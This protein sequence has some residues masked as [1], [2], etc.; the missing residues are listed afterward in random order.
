MT[1]HSNVV[2]DLHLDHVLKAYQPYTAVGKEVLLTPFLP[3]DEE[4]WQQEMDEQ[5]RIRQRGETQLD[6]MVHLQKHFIEA[7]VIKHLCLKLKNSESLAVTEW[8][9]LKRFLWTL[10]IWFKEM[11]DAGMNTTLCLTQEEGRRCE[12]LLWKL[13]PTPP[14]R[15]SFSL[16]SEYDERLAL[17]SSQLRRLERM[18]QLEKDRIAQEIEEAYGIRRNPFGEWVIGR[19][20]EVNTLLEKENRVKVSRETTHDLF[21]LLQWEGDPELAQEETSLQ[22]AIKVVEEEVMERL[23]TFFYS[24]V[25]DLEKWEQKLAHFDRLWA[26]VRAARSWQGVK[27]TLSTEHFSLQGGFHP[28]VRDSLEEKG[29]TCTPIDFHMVPGTAVIIGPNMGGKTVALKT[30]GVIAALAQ[31]G[32]YVPAT[33]CDLPL[34][35]W[36]GTVLHDE[37]QIHRGLS[38]Y[39]AEIS[40]L[41]TWIQK[42]GRGLLL[43]DELGRTTN[44]VEGSALVRAVA[45]FLRDAQKWSVLVTHYREIQEVEGTQGYRIAGFPSE[46]IGCCNRGELAVSIQEYM[47]YQ[48]IRMEPGDTL[49]QQ[50][51]LIADL[52]GLDSRIVLEAQ[53]LVEQDRACRQHL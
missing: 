16:E 51:L 50:A 52:L 11:Q 29:S 14:L 23:S 38:S 35:P 45:S 3:G 2:Q 20:Q 32:F 31:L 33:A 9:I 44:P 37:Q 47:D 34:F 25:P 18:R 6:S 26:R 49:P 1:F 8:F 7:P 41:Q 40:Q 24:V 22:E 30:V 39:G 10:H 13:N 19:D 53:R 46:L 48:L 28:C 43:M 12:E 21:Y 17:K 42:P 27:P 4:K 36:I 15:H 5:E